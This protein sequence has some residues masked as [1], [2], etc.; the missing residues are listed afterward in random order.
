MTPSQLQTLT[1][2]LSEHF[3]TDV[4]VRAQRALSGGCIHNAVYLA[5]NIGEFFCKHNQRAHYDNFTAEADGLEQLGSTRTLA[6]P[7]VHI[8]AETDQDAFLVL[9]YVHPGKPSTHFWE[10]FG[11]QLAALHRHRQPAF[12]YARDNYIGALPQSNRQHMDW[13]EFFIVERLQPMV[14]RAVATQQMSHKDAQRFDA[15]YPKLSAVFPAE[16]PALLH[17]DLW[18]GNFLCSANGAPVVFDPAVYFGHREAELAFMQLFGGFDDRLFQ[19][20][21]AAFPL[22]PNW[23]ARIDTFNLYPLLVHLNLFGRSYWPAIERTLR[24]YGV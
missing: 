17:G 16:P 11:E 9:E 20:Y 19:A 8:V 4:K 2:L 18:S 24:Q 22:A 14:A 10:Q 23:H 15:L 12:G 21:H 3:R 13:T 5:T 1:R 6:V 7:A